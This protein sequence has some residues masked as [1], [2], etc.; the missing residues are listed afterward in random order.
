MK[1]IED[2]HPGSYEM[3]FIEKLVRDGI[4]IVSSRP[5]IPHTPKKIS[6]TAE[7]LQKLVPETFKKLIWRE[8]R[9]RQVELKNSPIAP[10]ELPAP[11]PRIESRNKISEPIHNI[12]VSDRIHACLMRLLA[13]G[14]VKAPVLLSPDLHICKVELNHV[15]SKAIVQWS[16]LD[17]VDER[18]ISS[19]DEAF[20]ENRKIIGHLI[21]QQVKTKF[22][23]S[24]FFEYREDPFKE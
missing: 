24:Y 3:S 4:I 5:P 22:I 23:P 21:G 16:L 12:K 13:S 7:E 20:H 1:K 15:R 6:M 8:Q 19:I 2:S 18:R 17:N 11:P 14:K 10:A 9:D